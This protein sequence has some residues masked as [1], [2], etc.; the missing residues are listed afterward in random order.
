[1]M[2]EK[3]RP[4]TKMKHTRTITPTAKILVQKPKGTKCSLGP[5]EKRSPENAI[6]G[7]ADANTN[8]N[9]RTKTHCYI[10]IGEHKRKNASLKRNQ[11]KKKDEKN[12]H[13]C[14]NKKKSPGSL[15]LRQ[16]LYHSFHA[17]KSR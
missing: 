14:K 10:R 3:E 12:S 1:M 11:C 2:K 13:K 5:K 17:Q 7:N 8:A 4:L 6:D 9:K 16:A 15:R